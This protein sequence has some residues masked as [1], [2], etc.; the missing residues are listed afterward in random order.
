[1]TQWI[2]MRIK[3]RG[4]DAAGSRSY[5]HDARYTM[6]DKEKI[7]TNPSQPPFA[8]GRSKREIAALCSGRRVQV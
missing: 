7:T 4:R 3:E 5:R 2:G 1:M 6:Q 8:K